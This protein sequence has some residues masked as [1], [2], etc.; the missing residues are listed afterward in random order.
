MRVVVACLLLALPVAAHSAEK[1]KIVP[2]SKTGTTIKSDIADLGYINPSR[3]GVKYFELHA[4]PDMIV[5]ED[6]KYTPETP[7]APPS[8]D[9]RMYKPA[10][11]AHGP[12]ELVTPETFPNSGEVMLGKVASIGAKLD[13][14]I[15]TAKA[16]ATTKYQDLKNFLQ[17]FTTP[18]GIPS[19]GMPSSLS[20]KTF[21]MTNGST[22][23]LTYANWVTGMDP[24][25]MQNQY[26]SKT[27]KFKLTPTG[28]CYATGSTPTGP[29]ECFDGSSYNG[30]WLGRV[31]GFNGSAT[32]DPP[33]TP[34][35]EDVIDFAGVKNGLASASSAV[36]EEV[37]A[38]IK[39]IPNSKEKAADGVPSSVSGSSP[40][41][42]TQAEI[43]A[44][45]AKNTAAVAK[46]V[47]DATAQIAAANTN[48][49]NAQ[50]AAMQ[51][52]LDAAKAAQESEAI[53]GTAEGE[54]EGDDEETFAGINPEGFTEGYKATE[55]NFDIPGRFDSFL[56]NV[57]S[58]G[59]FS[60]SSGFFNSIPGGG[61]PVF[62]ING[63]QTFGSHS[64]DFS[65]TMTTGLAVLKSILLA[66]FG[67]LSIRAIIMKR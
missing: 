64:I 51:A 18:G 2:K 62:T 40:T 50:I 36:K 65:E 37:D 60:F 13:D 4:V 24:A 59:L 56:D 42:I 23:V 66:C 57:K 39:E 63:G 15:K 31:W 32:S 11:I 26:N 16:D 38:A 29:W 17:N 53:Q 54:E 22:V 52:A 1:L 45:L 28:G 43:D 9:D 35:T 33:T 19:S 21:T 25:Y 12:M 27:Y 58:S 3:P 5:S 14:I 41:G 49:A 34:P 46:M 20:G 6:A 10:L 67:F 55:E 48:D 30:T 47:A 8:K 44:L 61:S 7:D